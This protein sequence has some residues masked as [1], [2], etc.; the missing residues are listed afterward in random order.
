M[1]NHR[2]VNNNNNT[3]RLITPYKNRQGKSESSKKLERPP[4]IGRMPG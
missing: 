2:S 3:E 1:Q 4:Y